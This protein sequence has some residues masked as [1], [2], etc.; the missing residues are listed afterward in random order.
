MIYVMIN[1]ILLIFFEM[2]SVHLIM[3]FCKNFRLFKLKKKT[4]ILTFINSDKKIKMSFRLRYLG[5][6]KI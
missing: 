1:T 4:L 2:F 6:F 3:K 5:L